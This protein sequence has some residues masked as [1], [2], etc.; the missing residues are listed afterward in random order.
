MKMRDCPSECGTVDT[1]AWGV[2]K[3]Q[4]Q[5]VVRIKSPVKVEIKRR[6]QTTH[7]WVG[8]QY[9]NDAFWTWFYEVRSRNIPRE[10]AALLVENAAVCSESVSIL[11]LSRSG[12]EASETVRLRW[13]G[14]L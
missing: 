11:V 6:W 8:L 10:K 12:V 2:G 1:Y 5:A 3:T 14:I 9:L 7:M 4:I 13:N